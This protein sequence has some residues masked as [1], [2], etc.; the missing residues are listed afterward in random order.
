[1]D[2]INLNRWRLILGKNSGSDTSLTGEEAKMDQLLDFIYDREI[3]DERDIRG[4]SLDDSNITIPK[5]INGIRELFPKEAVEVM[6]KDALDL[7]NMTELLTDSSILENLTPNKE[8]LKNIL[9]MKNMLH[10]ETLEVARK[11]VKTIVE[12]LRKKFESE[13]QRSFSG[14]KLNNTTGGHRSIKNLDIKRTITDNLKNYNKELESIIVER[15]RFNQRVKDRNKWSVVVVVD[16]SGSMLDSVIHSAIMAGIFAKLPM[17]ET[18]L[19]IFDTE[20][21]DLTGY[22][23]DPVKTLMS[24]R[25]GGG[26]NITKALTYSESLIRNPQRT[27][28]ILVSDL[29]EGWSYR[30]MY[31]KAKDIIEGGSKLICLTSLDDQGGE[32]IYDRNAAK[33]I[34]NLGGHVAALT[35]GRVAEW[36][37]KIIS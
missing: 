27:I 30:E 16:E 24:V 14:R 6:E 34:A 12:E 19:V 25:L 2:K 20:V 11:I 13:I 1:M 7:Y 4:G 37:S 32:G 29:Y 35:P 9:A 21:V 18:K 36:I 22:I 8:L 5:W 28:V 23:D 33:K 15:V 10:G 26:T 31:R 17:L 3:D